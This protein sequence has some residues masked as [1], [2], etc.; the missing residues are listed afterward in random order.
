MSVCEWLFLHPQ[1]LPMRPVRPSSSVGIDCR[2]DEQRRRPSEAR[3]FQQPLLG[4]VRAL[5]TALARLL[6]MRAVKRSAEPDAA[7]R[8]NPDGGPLSNGDPGRDRSRCQNTNAR[9]PLMSN[10]SSSGLFRLP[11]SVV[12]VPVGRIRGRGRT[13]TSPHLR[14]REKRRARVYWRNRSLRSKILNFRKIR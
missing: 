7:R 3:L 10:P 2:N 13:R 9:S 11:P 14:R 4:R 5:D 6:W 1:S 12:I 8:V